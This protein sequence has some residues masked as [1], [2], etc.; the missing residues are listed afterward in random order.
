MSGIDTLNGTY[1]IDP[2]HTRIGFVVRH[3]MVTK[4]R[5][6]FNEVDGKA[7][8]GENLQDASID[9]TIDTASVDTRNADRDGHLKS[10]DFFDVEKYPTITFK[11]TDVQAKGDDLVVTGDLTI[12]DLTKSITIEF[13]Y[14]GG[15][16]DPFGNQ[17]VGFEGKTVVNRAEYGLTWNAALET[18]GVLVSDK[19]TLEFEISA[20][21]QA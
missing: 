16:T 5:G 20:I 9:V 11:S 4:V 12:K 6:S 18:G 10:A 13:E 1:V 14:E 15:A 17:R 7:V 8:T 3:A 2:S 21:R 19:V